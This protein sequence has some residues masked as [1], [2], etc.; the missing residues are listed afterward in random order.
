[1]WVLVLLGLVTAAFIFVIS[2]FVGP[3]FF[4]LFRYVGLFPV[5]LAPLF[6]K[7]V[8]S[9]V[10][11]DKISA[12][13]KFRIVYGFIAML[14][15]VA[16]A[17]VWFVIFVIQFIAD[18]MLWIGVISFGGA[19]LALIITYVMERNGY[20]YKQY[21]EAMKTLKKVRRIYEDDNIT[22]EYRRDI[23][24]YLCTIYRDLLCSQITGI[25]ICDAQGHLVTD[26]ILI[27]QIGKA[28]YLAGQYRQK[29]QVIKIIEKKLENINH[30]IDQLDEFLKEFSDLERAVYPD[31]DLYGIWYEINA[32]AE[33]IIK[34]GLFIEKLQ[35][36]KLLIWTDEF[37]PERY[38]SEQDI[39]DYEKMIASVL[40]EIDPLDKPTMNLVAEKCRQFQEKIEAEDYTTEVNISAYNQQH[41]QYITRVANLLLSIID[42]AGTTTPTLP[43]I[44]FTDAERTLLQEK[45][46]W[47]R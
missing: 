29:F 17:S 42:K 22:I 32:H 11:Q 19:L 28:V 16:V 1:M 15:L 41:N 23:S 10:K 43:D 30:Q 12:S 39:Q 45:I 34:H 36:E 5:I 7:P 47:G 13:K 46:D 26:Q 31:E 3:K 25:C 6:I 9:T 8:M 37:S 20:Y 18:S 44:S 40:E 24:S 14:S 4:F 38:V 21:P 2:L 27:N 33:N 35:Y